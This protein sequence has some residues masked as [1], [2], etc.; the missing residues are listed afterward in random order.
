MRDIG[1]DVKPPTGDW[2]DDE[3][4]PF[5]GSC[6]FVA[7]C[8]KDELLVWEWDVQLL[9]NA[10]MFDTCRSMSDMKSAQVHFQ[11]IFHVVSVA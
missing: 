4:C 8:L 11:H 6:A 9:L 10:I 1:V 5:Y 3:N 7:R 2:D